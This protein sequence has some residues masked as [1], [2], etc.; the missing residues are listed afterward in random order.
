M[1]YRASEIG[2]PRY[3]YLLQNWVFGAAY[4]TKTTCWSY[5]Q[6]RRMVAGKK[7][8]HEVGEFLLLHVPNECIKSLICG[9]QTDTETIQM[10]QQKA[11]EI[12]CDY[13]QLKIGRSSASPYLI[14]AD[15]ESYIFN[16]AGILKSS[17]CCSSCKE[18]LE[19]AAHFCSWCQ[20]DDSH[21]IAAAQRNPYRIFHE[22]GIL[23]A[24]LERM[25]NVSRGRR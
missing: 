10:L 17:H 19:R 15:G 12:E 5:E 4:F 11:N 14:G 21:R 23:D 2:K 13:F 25:S 1:L 22:L 7:E 9:P 24:Y 8:V 6:E 18:P 16:G 3:V 20:I